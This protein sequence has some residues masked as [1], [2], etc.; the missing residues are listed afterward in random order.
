LVSLVEAPFSFQPM[1][2]ND[3]A[4]ALTAAKNFLIRYI[5]T[6]K[7]FFSNNKWW[8][9]VEPLLERNETKAAIELFNA[10]FSDIMKLYIQ[11]VLLN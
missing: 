10:K 3:E 4:T 6:T 2:F 1:Q 5:S 11:E 8:V 7:V 9:E